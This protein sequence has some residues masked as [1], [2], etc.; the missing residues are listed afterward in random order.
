MAIKSAN[1]ILQS[2]THRKS[3]APGLPTASAPHRWR[4][5][6]LQ[7]PT[8]L[9]AASVIVSL[10]SVA[11]AFILSPIKIIPNTSWPSH[12]IMSKSDNDSCHHTY[13]RIVDP[14][15]NDLDV[16]IDAVNALISERLQARESKNFR[17]ADGILD[18][19]LT[20]HAVIVND[21]DLTWRTGTKRQVKKRKNI[22]LSKAKI[23]APSNNIS[24]RNDDFR[25][26]PNS[27][28]NL[29]TLSEEEIVTML[30][31]RHA[32]QRTRDYEKADAIRNTLKIA[33]VYIEDGMKEYRW[34]G[35]P[36]DTRRG[37]VREHGHASSPRPSLIRQSSHSLAL[38]DAEEVGIV[39]DL[40]AQRSKARSIGNYAKSDAIRDKLYESY[41]IRIDDRLGE[42]S[43]GGNF[44]T[45]DD[46]W[47]SSNRQRLA[48]YTKSEMSA[49]LPESDERYIQR[50]V[51]ERMRAKRTRNYDLSDSIRDK[52]YDIMM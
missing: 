37:R 4:W 49:N 16:D 3:M 20:Q 41:N 13:S 23:I 14:N 50:K 26:S 7:S 34:D 39:N 10:L 22:A 45:S 24:I 9:S 28:A 48:R 32:A 51:D 35:V 1:E 30:T 27:G 29:S 47:T 15:T 2:V 19:L 40:L 42:W 21:S 11:D 36:F 31:D 12:Q 43:V 17:R 52:L 6:L 5:L 33:G 25:L 18:Q 46:H 44:G 8:L 38:V